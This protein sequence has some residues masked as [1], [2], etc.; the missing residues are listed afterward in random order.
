MP[1]FSQPWQQWSDLMKNDEN[2]NIFDIDENLRLIGTAHVSSAS[3]ALVR[4]QISDYKPDI[5]AV[6]L[7]ESRLKSLK[8]PDEMDNED[9]LKIVNEGRSSMI[10]LQSALVAQQRR[11]GMNTGENPGAELLAAIEAAED[12]DIAYELIDRD[13]IITLRRAWRKMGLREKW[14]VLSV[15]L[16]DED[17]D[18]VVDIDDLLKDSDL[19]SELMLEAKQA[20][21]RAG[22][23]LIDERDAY[24]SG[25]I[26]QIRGG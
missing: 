24:L 5:V 9:L 11:M 22:E 2:R 16:R 6:E 19:L 14:R 8:Q 1:T 20:A 12:A 23:V 17:D 7:C 10:L 13:V 25:R 4:E 21:P 18:E 15:L 3:V 26:Q